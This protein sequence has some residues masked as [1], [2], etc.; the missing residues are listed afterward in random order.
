M[1]NTRTIKQLTEEEAKKVAEELAVAAEKSAAE[2]AKKAADEIA[3][4]VANVAEEVVK[5]GTAIAQE[6]LETGL[7]G[8]ESGVLEGVEQQSELDGEQAGENL[9]NQ[10]AT[11]L[12][13]ETPEAQ[14][15]RE[16]DGAG[17][18]F[19]AQAEVTTEA[20]TAEVAPKTREEHA[21][22]ILAKLND[23]FTNL[24]TNR[25]TQ[26]NRIKYAIE[27]GNHLL[28]TNKEYTHLEMLRG[29]LEVIWPIKLAI[30]KEYKERT[31]FTDP[32]RCRLYQKIA[33]LINPS[34]VLFLSKDFF[35]YL[36]TK[37]EVK[38]IENNKEA[39][40]KPA[41]LVKGKTTDL[42]KS[43]LVSTS[44][45]KTIDAASVKVS[46]NHLV[47]FFDRKK[48]KNVGEPEIKSCFKMG[49]VK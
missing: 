9:V 31:I 12:G 5:N 35:Q 42:T 34:L 37:Y 4:V 28:E 46:V 18:G 33:L 44:D 13:L 11:E 7:E 17:V 16:E 1:L 10:V 15:R 20:V 27:V 25:T 38:P 39:E 48:L 21:K 36:D 26:T 49:T 2:K 19:E 3:V 47:R 6:I 32:M 41:A 23:E 45:N 30:E 22:E 14:V 24:D 43:T 29:V 8:A 40:E